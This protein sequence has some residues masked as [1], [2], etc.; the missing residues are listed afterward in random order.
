MI[1]KVRKY[2]TENA[3]RTLVQANVTTLLDYCN[4]LLVGL[5][6]TL[7]DLLQRVQNCAARV[8]K[9]VPKHAHISPV[10]KDLHW[11]PIKFR[12][13]YKVIM[14]TFKALNG[15]AP[16]YIMDL[17]TS[18]NPG[19]ALRSSNDNLLSVTQARYSA[20]G[21]RSFEVAA[22]KLWNGLPPPMR[23]ISS[24][25]VFKKTLKTY[26]FTLAFNDS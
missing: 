8:I 24:I 15:L 16:L 19:C 2:I 26:L 7:L 4:S 18:Y 23:K 6:K 25:D 10:L 9:C 22:P 13:D 11:L 20:Y 5:P 17:L 14:L 12:I 21:D 3:A 1:H